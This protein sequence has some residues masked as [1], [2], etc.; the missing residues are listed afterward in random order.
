MTNETMIKM[1]LM[2]W[3]ASLLA[4]ASAIGAWWFFTLKAMGEAMAC[5]IFAGGLFVA[6]VFLVSMSAFALDNDS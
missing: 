2:M 6:T 4:G 1:I 5:G 3:G